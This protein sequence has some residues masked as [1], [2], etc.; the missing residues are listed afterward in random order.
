MC[1]PLFSYLNIAAHIVHKL[2]VINT[3]FPKQ[4]ENMLMG[5]GG[6]RMSLLLVIEARRGGVHMATATTDSSIAIMTV[7]IIHLLLLMML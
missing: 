1:S 7:I 2:N 5:L 6:V 3:T 4:I